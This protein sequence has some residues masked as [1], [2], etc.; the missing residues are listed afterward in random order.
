[1]PGQLAMLLAQM[2]QSLT[3]MGVHAFNACLQK[4]EE[5]L[6]LLVKIL[7]GYGSPPQGESLHST[8]LFLRQ[9]L[10]TKTSRCTAGQRVSTGGMANKYILISSSC[11][12]IQ[13][14]R[15]PCST[16]LYILPAGKRFLFSASSKSSVIKP[17]AKQLHGKLLIS[18]VLSNPG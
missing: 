13:H 17:Q 12:C 5:A 16:L 3:H 10:N 9:A 18:P 15:E 7:E 4:Q 6:S 11:P 2:R 8:C 1:M 14:G